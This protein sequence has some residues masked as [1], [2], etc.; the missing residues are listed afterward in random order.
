MAKPYPNVPQEKENEN[1]IEELLAENAPIDIFKGRLISLRSDFQV[2]NNNSTV[3]IPQGGS[4]ISNGAV[5]VATW[6][7]PRFNGKEQMIFGCGKVDSQNQFLHVSLKPTMLNFGFG[8]ND[9][10]LADATPIRNNQWTHIAA[11]FNTHKGKSIYINGRRVKEWTMETDKC[12]CAKFDVWV[13]KYPNAQ[14]GS[15]GEK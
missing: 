2:G 8:S 1:E 9:C 3:K 15:G 4:L 14:Q 12:N 7:K 6:V 5:T 11:V 13:G 10:L